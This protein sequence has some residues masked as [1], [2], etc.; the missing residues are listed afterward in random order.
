M[1][2]W[3]QIELSSSIDK[4]PIVKRLK[5]ENVNGQHRE[6]THH[7]ERVRLEKKDKE[8]PANKNLNLNEKVDAKKT[9]RRME[10]DGLGEESR[11]R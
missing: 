7:C 4:Q 3:R 2:N 9:Q 8:R 10:V 6:K 1:S 5:L 11:R